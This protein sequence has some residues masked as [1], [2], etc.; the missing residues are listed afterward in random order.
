MKIARKI[1][2]FIFS[3][4]AFVVF[5]VIMILLFPFIILASLPGSEKGGNII[6]ILCRV[7]S[8]SCLFLWGIRHRNIYQVPHDPGHACIFVFNHISYLDIP[9]LMVAFRHQHIRVLGKIEMT[10]I[11]IFGFIYRHAVITVDRSDAAH[12][13]QSVLNLKSMLRKNISVVLAPEGTFNMTHKP[14]KEFYDGAFRIAIETQTPIKPV[15]FLDAYDRLNYTSIF[16][17][18][19]GRSRAIYLEEI[20]VEGLTASDTEMLKQ[21]VYHKMEEA[22]VSHRATWIQ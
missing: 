17:L 5:L 4:Y 6:Y 14:L 10:K 16:S 1:A 15:V 22:L 2:G 7:W 18:N 13:A 21:Q 3:I 20:Q 11:P 19:P 12:R 8:Y 9:I